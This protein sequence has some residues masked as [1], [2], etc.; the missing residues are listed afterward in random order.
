M[1]ELRSLTAA[2]TYQ[3]RRLRE[4]VELCEGPDPDHPL[5]EFSRRRIA[6]L[7]KQIGEQKKQ[8]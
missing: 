1:S 7:E 4:L 6:W 5:Q 3:R 8:A 2:L